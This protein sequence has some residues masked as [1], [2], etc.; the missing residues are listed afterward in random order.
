MFTVEDIFL[1]ISDTKSI[2]KNM[3]SRKHVSIAKSFLCK[4]GKW[5]AD[6]K[7]KNEGT[8]GKRVTELYVYHEKYMKKIVINPWLSQGYMC[9]NTGKIG[10]FDAEKL[11]ET[12]PVLAL[13]NERFG[14]II[15]NHGIPYGIVCQTGFGDG[16]YEI[17]T[18]VY[19]DRVIA[20]KIIFITERERE[21]MRNIRNLDSES[22][23]EET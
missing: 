16:T 13:E 23:E 18:C 12:E 1:H 6:I 7:I 15:E 5:I 10:I 17:F 22:D 3:I 2:T 11:Y 20:V 4:P 21:F 8:L 9:V 14:K 19:K